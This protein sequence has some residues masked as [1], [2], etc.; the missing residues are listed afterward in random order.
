MRD[1]PS[2][3]DRARALTEAYFPNLNA[4]ALEFQRTSLGIQQAIIA[5]RKKVLAGTFESWDSAAY[6]AAYDPYLAACSDLR[7]KVLEEMHTRAGRRT[8]RR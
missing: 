5:E 7:R 3:V 8:A 2:G 6:S 4:A 1:W